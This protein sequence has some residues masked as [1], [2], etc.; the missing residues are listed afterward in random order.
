[1]GGGIGTYE[2]AMLSPPW[3][4]FP[5]GGGK[6]QISAVRFGYPILLSGII[7]I[8]RHQLPLPTRTSR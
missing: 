1:M 7:G 6:G 8:L 4:L 5:R 2:G 3:R